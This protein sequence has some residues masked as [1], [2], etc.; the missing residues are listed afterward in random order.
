MRASFVR[1][2]LAR[3]YAETFFEIYDNILIKKC[4]CSSHHRLR[5]RAQCYQVGILDFIKT[6]L[7][8]F[9]DAVTDK[10]I[11][12]KLI[13]I[14]EENQITCSEIPAY[15]FTKQYKDWVFKYAH[16]CT[17]MSNNLF[18]NKRSWYKPSEYKLYRLYCRNTF[19]N[20]N[21]DVLKVWYN[22]LEY[23][24]IKL[25][26]E[27]IKVKLNINDNEMFSYIGLCYFNCNCH[28]YCSRE[29]LRSLFNGQGVYGELMKNEI[30]MCRA[31]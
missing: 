6:H 5:S 22:K 10:T 4:T 23:E 26:W 2:A 9:K 27:L 18:I 8:D 25:I 17:S 1:H 24:L 19:I 28:K 3:A 15:V 12:E 21:T 16:E 31:K 13:K 20:D 29:T 14:C 30:A 7:Y 11:H